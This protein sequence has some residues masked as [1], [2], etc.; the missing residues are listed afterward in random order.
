MSNT[1]ID[2]WDLIK[3]CIIVGSIVIIVFI[4]MNIMAH[5]N[6]HVWFINWVFSLPLDRKIEASCGLFSFLTA[7]AWLSIRM[8]KKNMSNI[9]TYDYSR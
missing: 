3:W 6:F 4:V 2:V 8:W 1:V 9:I 7:G 5:F